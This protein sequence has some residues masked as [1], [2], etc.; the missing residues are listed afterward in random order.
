MTSVITSGAVTIAP[1]LVLGYQSSRTTGNIFHDIIGR[2]EDV[3][4]LRP[5]KFR[6]GTLRL[7]FLTENAAKA[8]EDA[9]AAATTFDYIDTDNTTTNM[10]YAVN[11]AVT[12]EQAEG[13]KRWIV[14]VDYKQV[15]P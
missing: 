15:S 1:E 13:G 11:G 3:V 8:A 5:A 9:H 7:F 14:N 6:T 4:T 2:A 10:R 12:R